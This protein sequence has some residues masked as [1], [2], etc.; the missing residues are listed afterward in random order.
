MR[1]LLSFLMCLALLFGLASAQG[2]DRWRQVFDPSGDSGLLTA[3]FLQL[4]ASGEE[5]S[6]DCAILTSPDGK[7]LVLDTGETTCSQQVVNALKALGVTKVDI[8]LLSHPH[9][10]HIG[11]ACAV[12]DAFPVDTVYTNGVA[13]P[14]S[15]TYLKT[16][17]AIETSGASHQVLKEGDTFSFGRQ[18]QAQVFWPE[19]KIEYYEGFPENSTQFMNNHSILVKFTFGESSMLFGGD[20]YTGVE[21]EIAARY[22]D[23]LRADVLKVGH[24]G[25]AYASSKTWRAAVSPK[26]AVV[27]DDGLSDPRLLEKYQEG[28]A[29]V[30][31]TLFDGCVKIS[32][33]GDGRYQALTSLDRPADFLP[34][35]E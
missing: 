22:G 15:K 8:L 6:G 5:K 11:G 24:H 29:K 25:N 9:I 1:K 10:D 3:R 34:M 7:V 20:L 26:I 14:T 33:A 17:A 35:P 32:T 27:M 4:T 30:Y 2:E 31:H 12:M 13:Y 16:M 19:E 21:R 18:V 23:S 28:G